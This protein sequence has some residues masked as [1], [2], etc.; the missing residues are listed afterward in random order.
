[1]G[2]AQASAA[3]GGLAQLLRYLLEK[4]IVDEQLVTTIRDEML[5]GLDPSVA[6]PTDRGLQLAYHNTLVSFAFLP[7]EPPPLMEPESDSAKVFGAA[8]DNK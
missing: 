4:G 6:D 1:M 5:M 7:T 3:H 8:I 2:E